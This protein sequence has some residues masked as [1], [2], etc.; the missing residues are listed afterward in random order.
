MKNVL[1][2]CFVDEERMRKEATEKVYKEKLEKMKAEAAEF[3]KHYAAGKAPSQ[4][5][6]NELMNMSK[7]LTSGSLVSEMVL[8][9]NYLV[10]PKPQNKNKLVFKDRI[11]GKQLFAKNTA[12]EHAWFDISMENEPDGQ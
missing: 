6:I 1:L 2:F 5:Q 4:S 10:E 7:A 11:D 8:W 3:Q 12:I 9:G